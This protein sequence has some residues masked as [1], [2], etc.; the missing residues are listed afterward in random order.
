MKMFGVGK[1]CISCNFN[2][3]SQYSNA[4]R[5]ELGSIGPSRKLQV[6][7][8]RVESG[9]KSGFVMKNIFYHSLTIIVG[10][11][12]EHFHF[13][14][15]HGNARCGRRFRPHLEALARSRVLERIPSS[16]QKCP[17][18]FCANNCHKCRSS[19]IRDFCLCNGK[20]FPSVKSQEFS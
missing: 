14:D 15:A 18:D 3:N 7:H 12:E 10:P 16:Y 2:Q 11:I 5:L 9:I 20:A 4:I 19:S 13:V 1:I 6:T 8:L 17:E